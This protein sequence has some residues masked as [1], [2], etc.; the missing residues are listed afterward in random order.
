MLEE[1][2]TTEKMELSVRAR[3][4]DQSGGGFRQ[5]SSLSCILSPSRSQ[6][7]SGLFSGWRKTKKKGGPIAR[8][9]HS[10]QQ[11][12]KAKFT[13]EGMRDVCPAVV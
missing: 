2:T 1:T 13:E 12:G 5:V 9:T 8:K 10:C 4:D 6:T 3:D 11:K 7:T